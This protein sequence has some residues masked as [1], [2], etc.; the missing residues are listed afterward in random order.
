MYVLIGTSGTATAE[1]ISLPLPSYEVSK[2][3]FLFEKVIC[4]SLSDELSSE[5]SFEARFLV[6]PR[7]KLIVWYP[8]L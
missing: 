4:H 3:I 1:A 6:L 5:L 7:K 2:S 8:A